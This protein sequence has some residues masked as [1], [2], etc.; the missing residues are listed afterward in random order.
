MVTTATC[1]INRNES[2]KGH[3]VVT[4]ATCVINRNESYK[5]R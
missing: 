2:Y 5:G 1:V 3:T 4:T